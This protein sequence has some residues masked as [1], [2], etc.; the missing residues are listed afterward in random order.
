MSEA[1]ATPPLVDALGSLHEPTLRRVCA[2]LIALRERNDRQH[3]VFEQS[4][5]QA[6]DDL[7]NKFDRFAADTQAAYQRLRD[8]LTGEKRHSLALL[9]ALVDLALD[10]QKVSAARPP[11]DD[12]T[13]ASWA[14]GVGVAARRAEAVL[15]QFGVHRYDAVVGSAYQPALHERVGSRPVDGM[16]P[17]L[18]A[19]QVEPG[20]ASQQ[21]D[22]ILRRAKVLITE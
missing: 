4:L 19:Q 15:G 17:L 14:D 9:N 1:D 2:E 7:Q 8:E 5:A 21:P 6:R 12:P 20:Y 13:G 22:F 10:L 3:R 16:G 18:V 11:I